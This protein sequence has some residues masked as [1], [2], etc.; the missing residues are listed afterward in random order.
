MP[1]LELSKCTP[2]LRVLDASG[3]LFLYKE[4]ADILAHL[5][6]GNTF[7][8]VCKS[9]ASGMLPQK[10]LYR[11]RVI[12]RTAAAV[13]CRILALGPGHPY[14]SDDL[15]AELRDEIAREKVLWMQRTITFAEEALIRDSVV[16][17]RGS[18]EYEWTSSIA[19]VFWLRVVLRD[20]LKRYT[21]GE[22]REMFFTVRVSNFDWFLGRTRSGLDMYT[23]TVD[24]LDTL[25]HSIHGHAHETVLQQNSDTAQTRLNYYLFHTAGIMAALEMYKD[26][27]DVWVDL[28]A[29][30][31][32]DNR[33]I[34][35][36]EKRLTVFCEVVTK[37]LR[38]THCHASSSIQGMIFNTIWDVPKPLVYEL[39]LGIERWCGS[40]SALFSALQTW[41]TGRQDFQ[42]IATGLNEGPNKLTPMFLINA[43]SRINANW[44]TKELPRRTGYHVLGCIA[45]FESTGEH[46]SQAISS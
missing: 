20:H 19:E 30:I 41:A 7:E 13:A 16:V 28:V 9:A 2:M 4:D 6:H 40:N 25:C 29:I 12:Y 22:A 24:E 18:P 34:D 43:A 14:L 3:S 21:L 1:I 8:R 39:A 42:F 5:F 27:A 45:W 32:S 44:K 38:S 23:M 36:F 33:D 26:M 46:T 17:D 11:N 10:Q 35:T 31:S 37:P 15:L